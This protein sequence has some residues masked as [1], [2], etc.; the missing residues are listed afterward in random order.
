MSR[1]R[2]TRLATINARDF[3]EVN[4]ETPRLREGVQLM[5]CATPIR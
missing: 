4:Q 1:L 2:L 3:S 5:R